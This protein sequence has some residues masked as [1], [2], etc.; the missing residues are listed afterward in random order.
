MC[1]HSSACQ[2]HRPRHRSN[3]PPLIGRMG[4]NLRRRVPNAEGG[5]KKKSLKIPHTP[6]LPAA[7]QQAMPAKSPQMG[8]QESLQTTGKLRV[9]GGRFSP[10]DS[11][12][13]TAIVPRRASPGPGASLARNISIL[14]HRRRPYG[15]LPQRGLG[16]RAL[17]RQRHVARAIG[18]MVLSPA[19][20]RVEP[21]PTF[22]P[23]SRRDSAHAPALLTF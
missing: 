10:S 15:G 22:H 21:K 3:S 13:G 8:D 6:L 12:L 18:A 4:R 9:G 5:P 17:C 11:Q 16:S 23:E 2:D 14:R 1:S 20:Q 19:L 7:P